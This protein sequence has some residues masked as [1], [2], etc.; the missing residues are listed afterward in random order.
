MRFQSIP[1]LLVG[2]SMVISGAAKAAPALLPTG[3][4]GIYAFPAPPAGFNPLTASDADLAAYGLPPRPSQFARNP[5]A[6]TAWAHAM[7]S[8]RMYVAPQI[9]LSLR[10]HGPVQ[11][12]SRL[13]LGSNG[14]MTSTNWAGQ[15]IDNSLGSYGSSSFGEVM[16]A[17]IVTAVQQAIG[18]CSGTDVSATWVGLDGTGTSKDVLQAGTEADAACSGGVT[19]RDYYPWFE[20]YPADTYEVTNFSTYPGQPV[21]VVVQAKSATSGVATFVDLESNQYTAVTIT[22]PSGTKLIGNSVEWVEERPSNTKGV[23]GTL[24][25]Y[26]QVWISS[27]ITYQEDQIG[28]AAYEVAGAPGNTGTAYTL[29]MQ[30]SAGVTISTSAPQGTAAQVIAVTGSA[31]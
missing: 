18:T 4:P 29:T 6:Y 20:W 1:L 8:A 10:R 12:T 7:A 16:G 2:M 17:W 25:D 22:P 9:R 31:K 11:A 14:V 27:E 5:A 30:T 26:G 21:Y 3:V 28:T 24:A 15:E 13:K 23:I 19:T